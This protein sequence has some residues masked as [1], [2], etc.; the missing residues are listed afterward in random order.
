[1]ALISN[2]TQACSINPTT[3]GAM[4]CTSD[5][6]LKKNINKV[7]QYSALQS[8][9][10]LETVTYNWKKGDTSVH[11]GYIAQQVEKVLPELVVTDERGFRQV[12]YSGFVPVITAA[13]QALHRFNGNHQ[14]DIDRLKFE[15][16]QL[17]SQI[18][19][20]QVEL[21]KQKNEIEQQK[22]EID[23]IKRKLG[24]N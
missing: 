18:N 22:N 11:I 13:I 12:S 19:S 10:N 20:Q 3:I 16:N 7:D 1:M 17:H 15:N 8:I 5:E 6:R 21:S 9:L 23:A 4:T 2:G 14:V 24:M